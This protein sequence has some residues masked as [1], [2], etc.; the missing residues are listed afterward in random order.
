M[1]L[2]IS[3]MVPDVQNVAT[4]VTERSAS[5]FVKAYQSS[6]VITPGVLR[7]P[8]LGHNILW[9]PNRC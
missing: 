7:E 5:K 1:I 2:P 6:S 4:L 9:F 8:S 3:L